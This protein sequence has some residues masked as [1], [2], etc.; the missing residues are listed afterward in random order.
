MLL[1]QYCMPQLQALPFLPAHTAF[2]CVKTMVRL[3]VLA[4]FNVRTDVL[5]AIARGGCA[6][7]SVRESARKADWEK[8]S[9]AAAAESGGTASALPRLGL[10]FR[11]HVLPTG[12]PGLTHTGWKEVQIQPHVLTNYQRDCSASSVH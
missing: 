10:A 11:A 4:V 6:A 12:R 7:N 8:K 1:Q 3:S 2:L 5:H 9:L